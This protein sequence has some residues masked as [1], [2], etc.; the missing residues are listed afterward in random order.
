MPVLI[1]ESQSLFRIAYMLHEPSKAYL[2]RKGIKQIIIG[3]VTF[4]KRVLPPLSFNLVAAKNFRKFSELLMQQS[5]TLNGASG[6]LHNCLCFDADSPTY[7]FFR[8]KRVN[9]NL[10]ISF[11]IY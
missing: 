10:K 11:S 1:D 5:P 9:L 6:H 3:A 2:K 7:G 4:L 8:K